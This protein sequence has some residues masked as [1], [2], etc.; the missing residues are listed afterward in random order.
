MSCPPASST[1][2]QSR[3]A[4]GF[5]SMRAALI[6][7]LILGLAPPVDA[8]TLDTAGLKAK[9]T[10]ETPGGKAIDVPDHGEAFRLRVDLTDV[11][12]GRAPKGLE[13]AG[14]IRRVDRLNRSCEDEARAYRVTRAIAEGAVDLNGIVLAALNEDASV[15]V[16]DPRL[17][18][19]PANMLAAA[20]LDSMPDDFIIDRVNMRALFAFKDAGRIEAISLADGARSV[21]AEGLGEAVAI[22]SVEDGSVWIASTNGSIGK[23][24]EGSRDEILQLGAGAVRLDNVPGNRIAAVSENGAVALLDGIGGR[25]LFQGNIGQSLVASALVGSEGLLSVSGDGKTAELR[26]FDDFGRAI[27]IPLGIAAS[28]LAIS[29]DARLALAF[30]PGSALVVVVDLAAAKVAQS[31]ALNNGTVAETGFTERAA[32]IATNE[33]DYIA[34]LDL[35]SVKQGAAPVIRPVPLGGK[36]GASNG[37]R[38]LLASLPPSPNMLVVDRDSATGWIV[39]ER[40]AVGNVP[41][42]DSIRLR[43][44]VPLQ[45]LVADRSFRESM[46][47]RFETVAKV[48][49]GGPH[50]LVLTTGISGLTACIPFN[51]NGPAATAASRIFHVSVAAAD[52]PYRALAPQQ[53][54]FTFSDEQGRRIDVESA[55]FLLPSLA[56][57]WSQEIVAHRAPDGKLKATVRFPHA[58]LYAVQPLDVPK[59][60]QLKSTPLIEVSS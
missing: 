45:V 18:G 25:I 39:P 35:N 2:S 44:G 27:P 51:V 19:Q 22:A 6:S 30:E 59:G 15:G 42:M 49:E 17:N 38:R 54:E 10:L 14:W 20:A 3:L 31:F 24:L 56:S 50:E 48:G 55:R 60:W 52:G 21:L 46:P 1:T 43:G 26:Y 33:G 58:G 53:V 34:V 5:N 57:A 40:A 4:R 23:I 13:L 47:G 28:K 11:A 36:G 8:Q 7:L 12:T 29:P 32:F 9:L 16:I 37:E 41:P